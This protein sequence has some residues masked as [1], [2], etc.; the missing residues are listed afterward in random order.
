GWYNKTLKK[1]CGNG[2][3]SFIHI[4]CDLYESTLDVLEYCKDYLQQGTVILFDDWYAF[5]GDNNSG[6]RKA[7][8]EIN[9]K[10]GLKWNNFPATGC[11]RAFI[12]Q[13]QT[14]Q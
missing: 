8:K 10:Y 7:F 13:D 6:E 5:K 14:K 12:Y 3:L 2:K 1:P 9:D 4:D 11:Q